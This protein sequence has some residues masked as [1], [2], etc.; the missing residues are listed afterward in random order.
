MRSVVAVHASARSPSPWDLVHVEADDGVWVVGFAG[1]PV[2]IDDRVRLARIDDGIA[3]YL[4][5]GGDG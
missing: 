5:V 1:A 2:A 4:P 3:V